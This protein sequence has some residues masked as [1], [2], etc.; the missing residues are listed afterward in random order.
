[1]ILL[2]GWSIAR[3]GGLAMIALY[4]FYIATLF[5]RTPLGLAA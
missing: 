4:V 5:E 2:K 3:L 1:V